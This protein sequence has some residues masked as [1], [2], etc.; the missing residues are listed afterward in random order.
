MGG[1]AERSG[2]SA[3]AQLCRGCLG[4]LRGSGEA[5]ASLWRVSGESLASLWRVSDGLWRGDRWGSRRPGRCCN[6]AVEKNRQVGVRPRP[7]RAEEL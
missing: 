1:D 5:L 6:C 2:G 7:P 4:S 3:Q